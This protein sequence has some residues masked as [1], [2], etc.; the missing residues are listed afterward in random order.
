MNWIDVDKIVIIIIIYTYFIY[1]LGN[2]DLNTIY[3]LFITLTKKY[4]NINN[5]RINYYISFLFY[6]NYNLH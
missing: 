6:N 2:Y 4:I 1:Y 3:I 5:R